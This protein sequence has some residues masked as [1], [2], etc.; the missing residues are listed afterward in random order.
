M[1]AYVNITRLYGIGDVIKN[2]TGG[3]MML[4]VV[5]PVCAVIYHS[6]YH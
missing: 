2:Q 1:P 3:R 5:T 4:N 6:L